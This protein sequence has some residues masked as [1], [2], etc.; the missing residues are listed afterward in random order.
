[1]YLQNSD[2]RHWVRVISIEGGESVAER[3]GQLGI[4]PGAV[5][6]VVRKAPF[7]GPVLVEVNGLEIAL[8]RNIASKVLVEAE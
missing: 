8:S 2:I 5:A 4:F 7:G 6:Q 3:L 1:M